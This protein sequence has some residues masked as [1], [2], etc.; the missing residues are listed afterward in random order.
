[1]E[2]LLTAL[3]EHDDIK[4]KLYVQSVQFEVACSL[5]SFVWESET[6]ENNYEN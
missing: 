5:H 6:K 2:N 3:K 4:M 1:M